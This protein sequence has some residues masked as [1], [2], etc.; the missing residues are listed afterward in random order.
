MNTFGPM[1]LAQLCVHE[2]NHSSL[3]QKYISILLSLEELVE[4]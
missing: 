3:K 4:V 2:H 1:S